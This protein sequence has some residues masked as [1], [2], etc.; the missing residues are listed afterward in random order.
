MNRRSLRWVVPVGVLAATVVALPSCGGQVDGGS[1]LLGAAESASDHT[2]TANASS[3]FAIGYGSSTS[4]D[5]V[6]GVGSSY[7]VGGSS[8]AGSWSSW[9]VSSGSSPGHNGGS[10]WDASV[11]YGSDASGFGIVGSACWESQLPPEVQPILPTASVSASCAAAPAITQWSSPVPRSDVDAG[12]DGD[13]RGAIVGRWVACAPGADP[14][15][16]AP[17][18]GIEFG[19][20]GRWRL[21]V[22]DS[23]GAL[24]PTTSTGTDAQ[25]RYYALTSGQIDIDDDGFTYG[26]IAFL[27]LS[28]D[29]NLVEFASESPSSGSVA[30]ARATPSPDNGDDNGPSTT[31]GTCSMV[32][33]WDLA[34]TAQSPAAT[35]SFDALGNFVGGPPGADLC[36]SHTMYGTYRL[37]S[38]MFQITENVGMGVCQWWF[39]AG[40]SA[41]FDATCTQLSLTEE[42]DNC[43]G[44]RGDFNGQ[45]TLTKRP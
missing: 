1:G 15:S 41:T 7:A 39:D 21:L 30:Y 6:H 9:D 32:G 26:R 19:A 33:T 2:S 42:Y 44:G 40:Y 31:D 22:T 4:A 20:N 12:P 16:M 34:M 10:A 14:F 24:V 5:Q 43:T 35:F 18:A 23:S 45:T 3:T 37:S 8:S 25:G 36:S 17:H 27:G 13:A 29:G 28:A 38:G 11:V